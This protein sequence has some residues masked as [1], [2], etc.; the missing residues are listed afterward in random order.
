MSMVT[1]SITLWMLYIVRP[2]TFLEISTSNSVPIAVRTDG[3]LQAGASTRTLFVDHYLPVGIHHRDRKGLRHLGAE[4]GSPGS[5]LASHTKSAAVCILT[6]TDCPS[7]QFSSH[8][9]LFSYGPL[10]KQK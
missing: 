10:L 4:Q 7:A 6:E 8:S 2:S 9:L 3:S 1:L 5:T